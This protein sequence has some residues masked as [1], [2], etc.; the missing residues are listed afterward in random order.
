MRHA[1]VLLNAFAIVPA[2]IFAQSDDRLPKS[3]R[4]VIQVDPSDRPNSLDQL[5]SFSPL[6]IEATVASN[7]P[8]FQREPHLPYM[9]ETHSVILVDDVL[10]G[11]VPGLA[12]SIVLAQTGGKVGNL[13]ISVPEAPVVVPKG[14]YLFFP[15]PDD[16]KLRVDTSGLPRYLVQ[17][18]WAGMVKID[19]D[20]KLVQVSQ[21]V[22][23]ALAAEV[24]KLTTDQLRAKINKKVK[25]ADLPGNKSLPIHPGGPTCIRSVITKLVPHKACCRRSAP[26]LAKQWTVPRYFVA[27]RPIL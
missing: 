9:V 27:A 23:E 8:S 20:N 12:R 2:V 17:G 24:G 13:E 26:P 11:E 25:G 21:G 15:V 6:V 4:I 14:R 3:G 7:L 16:R 19:P 22:Q 1:A 10:K 5:V 18:V